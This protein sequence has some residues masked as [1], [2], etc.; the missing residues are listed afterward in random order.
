M[1]SRKTAKTLE[2]NENDLMRITGGMLIG[3][4]RGPV[5]SAPTVSSGSSGNNSASSGGSTGDPTNQL[6]TKPR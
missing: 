2:L 5:R 4:S 3:I 1:K 6:E